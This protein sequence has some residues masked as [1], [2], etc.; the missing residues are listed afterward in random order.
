VAVVGHAAIISAGGDL[1]GLIDFGVNQRADRA[2]IRPTIIARA[3]FAVAISPSPCA[4]KL[5]S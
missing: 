2:G 4:A 1:L 5:T 3:L